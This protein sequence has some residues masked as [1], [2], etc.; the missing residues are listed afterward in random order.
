[1]RKKKLSMGWNECGWKI[2]YDKNKI[3]PSP[4]FITLTII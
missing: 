3:T 1:M 2:G 4:I